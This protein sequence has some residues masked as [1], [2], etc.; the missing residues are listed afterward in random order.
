MTQKISEFVV[1]LANLAE[2]EG[3]AFRHHASW[4]VIRLLVW[5]AAA[6]LLVLGI[7]AML[8]GMSWT[9]ALAVG[10]PVALILTGFASIVVGSI[11][12][13]VVRAIQ[14]AES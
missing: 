8:C 3:R 9:L 5:S 2:A 1:R 11:V 10:W 12:L 4:F 13:M 6:V 14:P 7:V